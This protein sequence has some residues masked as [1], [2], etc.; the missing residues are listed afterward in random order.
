MDTRAAF[1]DGGEG[2][3]LDGVRAYLREHREKDFVQNLSAKLLAYSLGRSLQPSDDATIEEM[4]TAPAADRYRFRR[5]IE[6]IVTSPQFRN[7][8]SD[9]PPDGDK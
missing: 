3:G 4:Q 1:P 6:A 2:T 5:L 7:R 9:G 8:R